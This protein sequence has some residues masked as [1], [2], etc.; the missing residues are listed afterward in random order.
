MRKLIRVLLVAF[1]LLLFMSIVLPRGGSHHLPRV[2]TGKADIAQFATALSMFYV[3]CGRYPTTVEGL[4]ALLKRPVAIPEHLWRGPYVDARTL[5]KDP[6]GRPYV[7]EWPGKHNTNGFDIYS[8]GRDGKGGDEAI[9][10][11]IAP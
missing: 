10:N 4:G 11:W 2:R 8:L 7:Y 9:G 1:I 3:D 6:W 5:P